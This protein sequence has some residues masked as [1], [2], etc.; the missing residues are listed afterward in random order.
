[1]LDQPLP[2][3]PVGPDR[4]VIPHMERCY[5]QLDVTLDGGLSLVKKTQHSDVHVDEVDISR[6]KREISEIL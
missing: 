2:A 3:G 6:I 5:R 1:M 4:K